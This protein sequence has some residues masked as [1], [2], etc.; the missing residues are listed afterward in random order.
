MYTFY[1][2]V[3]D[4]GYVEGHCYHG[5]C[6]AQKSCKFECR[7]F[8]DKLDSNLTGNMW[9]HATV[10]LLRLLSYFFSFPFL[11]PFRSL[12]LSRPSWSTLF[13]ILFLRS[14]SGQNHN[15]PWCS[16]TFYHSLLIVISLILPPS[17]PALEN[18]LRHYIYTSST[19]CNALHF[20]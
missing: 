14:F 18:Q 15:V 4:I 7:H 16:T 9:K 10:S 8:L 19:L 17:I 3:P 2:L 1:D 5:F 11:F 12:R 6:C 20:K 13:L